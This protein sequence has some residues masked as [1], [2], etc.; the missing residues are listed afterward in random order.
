MGP[1][2]SNPWPSPA[3]APAAR[4]LAIWEICQDM[5]ISAKASLVWACWSYSFR[6]SDT[7]VASLGSTRSESL[8]FAKM[9][10]IE[11]LRTKAKTWKHFEN[12]WKS[13]SDQPART[14]NASASPGPARRRSSAP[15]AHAGL[16]AKHCQALPSTST[17]HFM[18]LMMPSNTCRF[19]RGDKFRWMRCLGDIFRQLHGQSAG[20]QQAINVGE[21]SPE[22][23]GLTRFTRSFS[24]TRGAALKDVWK[25]CECNA[26]LLWGKGC[27]FCSFLQELRA[28]KAPK[29]V[30]ATQ[31]GVPREAAFGFH[32]NYRAD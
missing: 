27:S 8:K 17:L 10:L 1:A 12:M 20:Y 32:G 15:L 29:T 7:C 30:F 18:A 26:S 14:P 23:S 4:L 22:G 25:C 13:P 28:S 21:V 11:R 9:L 24:V 3:S 19:A 2:G 5:P 6:S 31:F 16:P